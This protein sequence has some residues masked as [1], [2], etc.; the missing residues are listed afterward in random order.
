MKNI[1]N[2]AGS[3]GHGTASPIR[4]GVFTVFSQPSTSVKI[5]GFGAHSTPLMF[6]FTGGDCDGFVPGSMFATGFINATSTSVSANGSKVMREDDTALIE[7]TG[8][9]PGG[10][11]STVF[12]AV[13]ISDAGQNAVKA[14]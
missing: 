7:F 13:V 1:M 6:S 3:L 11:T 8:N 14:D 4:N 5:D 12:G 10:G 9:L 2:A